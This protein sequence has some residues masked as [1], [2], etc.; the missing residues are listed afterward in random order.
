[1]NIVQTRSFEKVVKK[2]HANQKLD[3]D[4]A[5]KSIAENPNL[6]EEKVGDFAK[7]RVHK[8]KMV[9]QLMLLA[10][11]CEDQTVTLILLALGSHENF[12]RDLKKSN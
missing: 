10:Y 3:L 2:L 1:M 8:F 9:K 5:I 4:L 11:Q 7:V 6:G 12:Y